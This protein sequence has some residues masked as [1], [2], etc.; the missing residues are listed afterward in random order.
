MCLQIPHS[1][2]EELGMKSSSELLDAMQLPD[3]RTNSFF[4]L[5]GSQAPPP[6]GLVCAS[7]AAVPPDRCFRPAHCCVV[8]VLTT[9]PAD[10]RNRLQCAPEALSHVCD[11]L[12]SSL[13]NTV[14]I[15]LRF[16]ELEAIFPSAS[17]HWVCPTLCTSGR[18]LS[19][20]G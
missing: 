12:Q 4:L 19:W 11:S 5:L 17:A 18:L 6:P 8:T 13:L 1:T 3:S 7:R 2:N 10:Q 15:L 9:G 14:L 16:L 20:D